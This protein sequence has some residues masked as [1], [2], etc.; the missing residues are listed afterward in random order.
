MGLTSLRLSASAAHATRG[1][2][3][4]EQ[5]AQEHGDRERSIVHRAGEPEPG[6]RGFGGIG[7]FEP[8]IVRDVDLHRNDGRQTDGFPA[9]I[10]IGEG[11]P[12]PVTP[13]WM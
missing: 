11:F 6:V 4:V 7:L 10:R 13:D 2:L 1:L 5:R 12:H 3:A 8:N 9:R